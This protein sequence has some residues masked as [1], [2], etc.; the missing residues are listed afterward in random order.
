MRYSTELTQQIVL[1]YERGLSAQE[2]ATD[3]EKQLGHEVPERSIIA[4]LSSLG[5]YKRKVYTNKCGE[6][7]VKK[8]EYIE[9]ISK[10]LDIDLCLL[11]SLEKVTK[12]ALMLLDRQI[13]EL[14]KE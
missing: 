6:P 11:D 5:I 1:D 2:I 7:P 13:A 9:R 12:T 3:L 14:A 10:M 8:E 4:K